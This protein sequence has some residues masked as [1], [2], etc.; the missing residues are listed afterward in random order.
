MCWLLVGGSLL[1]ILGSLAGSSEVDWANWHVFF[2]DERNVAHSSPDSTIKGAREGFLSKA[3]SALPHVFKLASLVD[4]EAPR[5]VAF[6]VA[7]S[8]VAVL[9]KQQTCSA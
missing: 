4:M 8:P 9:C 3:R 7:S 1:K 6:V 2:G 5:C